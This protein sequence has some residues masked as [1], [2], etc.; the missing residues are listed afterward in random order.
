MINNAYR[1][2]GHLINTQANKHNVASLA[3]LQYT[4]SRGTI[5]EGVVTS[6]D[7]QYNL[8]VDLN[9]IRGIIKAEDAQYCRPDETWKGVALMKRVGKPVACKIVD[10]DMTGSEP[11][12]KLSRR[13]VQKECVE[14]YH[15]KLMIGDIIPARVTRTDTFGTFLDIGCGISALMPIAR[16]SLTRVNHTSERFHADMDLYVIVDTIDPHNRRITVSLRE[17]LGTWEENAAMFHPGQTVVGVLRQVED[18]GVFIELTPNLT[19]LA[20]IPTGKTAEDLKEQI[21]TNVPV[22][23]KSVNPENMKIKLVIL[24]DG[25]AK[26]Q[27][28]APKYFVD[29]EN[30]HHLTEWQYSPDCCIKKTVRTFFG[31]GFASET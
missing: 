9:G 23:I 22:Y 30:V 6:C 3:A 11:L 2:E 28:T 4:M 25:V 18:Y 8:H 24:D 27:V 13:D 10:I 12:V 21:G 15:A 19:G 16:S 14:N 17:L 31:D 5:I 7:A 29:C 1:P 26:A 20:E